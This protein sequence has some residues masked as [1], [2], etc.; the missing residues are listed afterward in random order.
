MTLR[1]TASN[2]THTAV[3]KTLLDKVWR[4]LPAG[5]GYSIN[6]TASHGS[7]TASAD[8]KVN[9]SSDAGIIGLSQPKTY[10]HLANDTAEYDV[11]R[12]I[13]PNAAANCQPHFELMLEGYN[14]GYGSTHDVDLYVT[15]E[16]P[17]R[18]FDQ[19]ELR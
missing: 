8:L 7:I 5:N 15:D 16:D 2:L 17:N 3:N 10:G 1:L 9:I 11:Y 18:R 6:V 14:I 4:G 12:L 19:R 13:R